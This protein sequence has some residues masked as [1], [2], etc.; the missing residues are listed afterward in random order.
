MVV[1]LIGVGV[2]DAVAIAGT[3]VALGTEVAG[4]VAV[5]KGGVVVPG[6][7]GEDRAQPV[8]MQTE[9]HRKTWRLPTQQ[10]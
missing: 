1:P 5:T 8:R 3:A 4:R 9:M 7:V 10:L 6:A 2:E